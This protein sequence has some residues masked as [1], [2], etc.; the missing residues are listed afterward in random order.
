ME[1]ASPDWQKARLVRFWRALLIPI[2]KAGIAPERD[3]RDSVCF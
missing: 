2:S 3:L 1:T